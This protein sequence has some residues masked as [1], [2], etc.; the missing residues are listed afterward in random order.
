MKPLP[1][2]TTFP[3]SRYAGPDG[4]FMM[5]GLAR[6]EL[7]PITVSAKPSQTQPGAWDRPAGKSDRTRSWPAGFRFADPCLGCSWACI[8][9]DRGT[10]KESASTVR[11]CFIHT[12]ILGWR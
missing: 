7:P 1:L 12:N 2:V 9:E 6:L 5:P 11:K 10:A 4:V 8:R 3:V